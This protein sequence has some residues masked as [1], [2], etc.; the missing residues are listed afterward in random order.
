MKDSGADKKAIA[1]YVEELLALK[2]QLEPSAPTP[3]KP[4]P[5]SA[6]SPDDDFITPRE[7]DYSA[8]YS[9]VIRHSSMAESSP[10][11][12]AMIIK[13][14]GMAI[15]DLLKE[16]MDARIKNEDVDNVYFPLLIPMSFLTKEAEHVD[17][18]AKECAVVTHHRLTGSPNDPTNLIA[19]PEAKLEEPLIIR[20]T[21]ETII[22]NS[23][24]NWITSHRDLPLK[25]NQWANVLRWELRTRPFLRTS[26]FLWQEGHTA[27][28]TPESAQEDALKMINVYSSFCTK[29]LAMPTIVGKKSPSERFAGA[30]ET[31]TIESLMQNGWCLQ[32]G[33]SHDLGQSFGKAFD[34][35]FQ[36]ADGSRSPVYGT[37]WGITT[38]LIG[39]MIMTHSDDSGLV[40]PPK[41]APKQVVIVPIPAKKNDEEGKKKL[42]DSLDNLV[43]DLKSRNIRVKVDDRDYIRNGAKYFEWERK[44]VPL[45]IE[46]GPRDV[47]KDVCVF[48]WRKWKDEKEVVELKSAADQVVDELEQ[49]Q[50]HLLEASSGRLAAGTRLDVTYDEMKSLLVNDEASKYPGAGLFLVP[51]KC[52]AENEEKIKEECKATLRCYPSEINDMKMYEGKKCFF[53]GE[54]ADRMAL[55]GRAF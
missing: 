43:S 14:W 47:A 50:A 7:T 42:Q 34:V 52:N 28:A 21:S 49:Y 16:D 32:S 10:T 12:G 53:S 8:W 41:I 15:W 39:A 46:L 4:K 13:P 23:F 45:R 6:E 44:G 35:E 25:I 51:W 38:R 29:M 19:D 2:A 26:E 31:Y 24:R 3:K 33:T 5:K 9:D 20:P 36:A 40:L 54:D 22:W 48:K 37:S 17:G 18:F 11:R 27:H 55:F 1:P 30:K